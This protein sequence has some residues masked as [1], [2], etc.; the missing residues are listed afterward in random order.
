MVYKDEASGYIFQKVM[1]D[2]GT[3]NIFTETEEGKLVKVDVFTNCEIGT[4]PEK[5]KQKCKEFAEYM[6]EA[7]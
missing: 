3:V 2:S 5:F 4:D 7:Y 6:M 1:G